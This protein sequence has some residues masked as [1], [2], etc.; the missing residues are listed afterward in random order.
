MN[1]GI[2]PVHIISI[3]SGDSVV[4]APKTRLAARHLTHDFATRPMKENV[5]IS[6]AQGKIPKI[7]PS[8]TI[9]LRSFFRKKFWKR[10]HITC[11]EFS[12]II[13]NMPRHK[14]KIPPPK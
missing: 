3:T 13:I 6:G 2:K 5:E 10:R 7:N 4:P 14:I 1:L 9:V 12:P 11:E 8:I